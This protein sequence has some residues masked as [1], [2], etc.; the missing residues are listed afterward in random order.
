[1]YPYFSGKILRFDCNTL[2]VL[3]SQTLMLQPL[4]L[5]ESGF[6]LW[7]SRRFAQRRASVRRWIHKQIPGH[8]NMTMAST[9]LILL[10][11]PGSI[12]ARI[13]KG[14]RGKQSQ[15]V[16]F[17]IPSTLARDVYQAQADFEWLWGYAD[18]GTRSPRHQETSGAHDALQY[19]LAAQR[20]RFECLAQN[21]S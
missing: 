14:V 12:D 1:M 4:R 2:L 19:H 11:F 15:Q 16:R 7:L 21:T 6:L 13:E 5:L 17:E 8:S 20:L 9:H 18:C 10:L 3:L